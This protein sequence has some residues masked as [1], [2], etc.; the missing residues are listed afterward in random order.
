MCLANINQC[1]H[2]KDEG[3][4]Q[5]YQDMENRPG[6]AGN[7]VANRQPNAGGGQGPGTTHEGDQQE[8]QLTSIQVTKQPQCQRN[9]FS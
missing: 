4:Q 5:N 1:Q 3:L 9:R 6:R 7:D 2:H 8:N